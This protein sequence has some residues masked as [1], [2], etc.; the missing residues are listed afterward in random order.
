MKRF[1]LATA[2][3]ALAITT[4]SAAPILPNG[5]EPYRAP[6]PENPIVQKAAAPQ[7][8]PVPPSLSQTSDSPDAISAGPQ[9]YR[10]PNPAN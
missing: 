1:S 10:A 9:P 7:P 6:T 3:L 2:G 8:D 5:P 4:A